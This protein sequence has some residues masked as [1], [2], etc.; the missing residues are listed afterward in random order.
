M[1]EP[2]PHRV[3]SVGVMALAHL[4]ND[5]YAYMLPALLPL[6]LGKLEIGLG[7][8]GLL[9]T[10]Y[11]ASS[12]FTQPLFGH[13]SDAGG[14]TRWMAW[15]GVALS[16]LAA[17]TLGLAPNIAVVAVALLAGG[18]GTALYHPVSAALVAGSVPQRSRGRWMSVYI[19]A[20]NFGLPVGPFFIGLIIATIGLGG[21]WLIAIPALILSIL[22]LRFG[23]TPPTR[24]AAPLSLRAVLSGNRRMLTGLVSVSATRAWASGLVST[25]LPLYAVSLGASIVDAS[26]LLTLFLLSGAVGG[27]IGGWLA[28]RLGRDRVIITS[29]LTAAPF[30]WLLAAQA[31]VG[32]AFVLA[33]AVS[34]ML[35][36]GSFVVLAVRGQES[37]PGSLGMVSGLMLGLSIGLGGLAVAPMGLVAERAG[38]PPVFLVAGILAI[39]GALFMRSVPRPP[40]GAP[41]HLPVAA[42]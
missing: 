20:G 30:C 4:T 19:S 6:L 24:T 8:A 13:M 27:L 16:G 12:S 33:A 34:G 9:V 29:L 3:A 23:P 38:I 15:T 14:R 17:A 7:V 25:F 35:L 32:P 21:S 39:G 31:A 36:N 5:S 1:S 11:Q 26:Q 22:V 10:L 28:D 37:M 41:L 40:I 2:A 18:L 42:G